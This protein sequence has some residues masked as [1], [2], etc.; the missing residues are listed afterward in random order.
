[1]VCPN[2]KNELTLPPRAYLN[3]EGYRDGGNILVS[4]KCCK[5]GYLVKKEVKYDITPHIGEK[6]ED[7][8][9]FDFT[10]AKI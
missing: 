7:D 6:K 5:A 1:M 8:W 10:R 3:L 2:C 9:G 4:S